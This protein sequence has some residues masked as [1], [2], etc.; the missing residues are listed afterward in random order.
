MCLPGSYSS[1]S[2]RLSLRT[3]RS[4]L[5]CPQAP[6]SFWRRSRFNISCKALSMISVL[7]FTP[8]SLAI[9]PKMSADMLSVVRICTSDMYYKCRSFLCQGAGKLTY[10]TQNYL[11]KNMRKNLDITQQFSN[12][13]LN[14][15]NELINLMNLS[16][17]LRL[18]R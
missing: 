14:K 10:I 4:T 13:E 8:E 7:L 6:F 18:K 11:S 1:S 12:K 3:S 2:L 5:I 15:Y 16:E 17:L 9:S